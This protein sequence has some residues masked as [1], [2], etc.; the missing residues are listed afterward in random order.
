MTFGSRL[1]IL[2]LAVIGYFAVREY[3]LLTT[4]PATL[5]DLALQQMQPS[6]EAAET[7][8]LADGSKNWLLSG[9]SVLLFTGVAAVCLFRNEL[10][11]FI[12]KAGA[13]ETRD[14]GASPPD[15]RVEG[16][17]LYPLDQG[18]LS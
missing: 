7:L 12:Q 13:G 15:K 1:F 2:L 14:R 3:L 5:T 10:A 9:W 11:H 8:R 6:D 4:A 18:E 17:N 16:G